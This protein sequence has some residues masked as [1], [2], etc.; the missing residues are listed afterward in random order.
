MFSELFARL[1]ANEVRVTLHEWLTLMEALE[2]GLIA[3][4]LTSF[5][6]GA[7]A[8]LVKREADFDRFD[9][10]FLGLYRG[11]ETGE[12]VLKSVLDWLDDPKRLRHLSPEEMAALE[13]LDLERLRELFEQRLKEQTERHDGGNR[14]VGTGGT[15]P[16]GHGGFHPTGVRVGGMGGGRQA[17]QIASK[18]RFQAYRNDI[19]LDTRQ[20][21]VALR[22]LRRLVRHGRQDELDVD[23]TIDRTGRNAGDL[24]LVFRAPRKNQIR[25]VLLMDAGGSMTPHARLVSR[26]FSAA[27]K[28]GQWKSFQSY[29][30]HNCVYET[31]WS[32][33]SMQDSTSVST[34]D[35][36]AEATSQSVLVM[37]GD[38]A[39][40][41]GELTERFGSIDYW[42]RNET[43][44]IEWLQR[45]RKAY[46]VNAWVNPMP[47]RWWNASSLYLIRRIF[48]MFPLTLLGLDEAVDHLRGHAS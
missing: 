39:M 29:Y 36:I 6:Y 3:P 46:S 1:R 17:V 44:G 10:V 7:R 26:L 2:R 32:D 23:E 13:G 42:H 30:F 41:P 19:V 40:H 22:R 9:E 43:P 48:P 27:S 21:Q 25:L 33:I 14:W 47:E 34:A 8:I 28:G 16:F 5:Y 35:L 38:A 20:I 24:E 45:L 37:V 12:E 31:V 15:S 18:R 4:D 11:V